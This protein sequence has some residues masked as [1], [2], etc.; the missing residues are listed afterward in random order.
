MNTF[1]VISRTNAFSKILTIFHEN[2]YFKKYVI[3]YTM[4]FLSKYHTNLIYHR[5]SEIIANLI[6]NMWALIA[7]LIQMT[8]IRYLMTKKKHN[9]HFKIVDE[10][11]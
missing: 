11:E 10:F 1:F 4:I 3:Y 6:Y 5:K 7:D 2:Q 8:H 9:V